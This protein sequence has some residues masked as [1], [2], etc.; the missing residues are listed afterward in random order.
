MLETYLLCP[1]ATRREFRVCAVVHRFVEKSRGCACS[2][3]PERPQRCGVRNIVRANGAPPTRASMVNRSLSTWSPQRRSR[4]RTKKSL[5]RGYVLGTSTSTTPQPGS[6]FSSVM[7]ASPSG[8]STVGAGPSSV[9]ARNNLN[10]W[11]AQAQSA[12]CRSLCTSPHPP[13]QT[14]PRRPSCI[15]QNGPGAGCHGPPFLSSTNAVKLKQTFLAARRQ[16]PSHRVPHGT[17]IIPS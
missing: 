13:T 4:A 2:A 5:P 8:V 12:R 1:A 16:Y 3:R 9:N 10:A 6:P 17:P 15:Q 14:R 7:R 11:I